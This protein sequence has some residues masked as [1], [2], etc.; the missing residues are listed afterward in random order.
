MFLSFSPDVD[1]LN[2]YY[3]SVK[4]VNKFPLQIFPWMERSFIP[5]N[6]SNLCVAPRNIGDLGLLWNFHLPILLGTL[7]ISVG[8]WNGQYILTIRYST[9]V[10]GYFLDLSPKV[11]TFHMKPLFNIYLKFKELSQGV[12][13]MEWDQ[14]LTIIILYTS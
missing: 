2:F 14:P 5:T 6:T 11:L 8:L 1:L 10:G 7:F 13:A 12:P 3:V 9:I 4:L